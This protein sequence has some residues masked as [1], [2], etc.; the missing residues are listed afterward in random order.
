V[1]IRLHTILLA[2]TSLLT[3]TLSAQQMPGFTQYQSTVMYSNPAYAGMREGICINGLMRQQWAGF[4]DTQRGDNV[5]PQT[6][7]ITVDSPIKFLHGGLGGSIIQDN[8]AAG[9]WKDV[10]LQLSYSFH[11]DLS[12]GLLGIGAGVNLINRSI[13]GSKYDPVD[14]VDGDQALLGSEQGD[15]RADVN[16]GLFLMNPGRYYFGIAVNNILET[17]YKKLYDG[18][19]DGGVINDRTFTVN[20]AYTFLLNNPRFEIEPS[21]MIISDISSTQYNLSAIV[22]YNDR[23]WGGLNARL[24]HFESIG[25]IVGV[26]FKDFRIGY[27]YDINLMGLSV[28]GSHEVSLGYCF[29]LKGDRSKTS[30][31]NTRYL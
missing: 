11:A 6:F 25:V 9:L 26:S 12:M 23:F 1:K 29:K 14:P 19:D 24:G 28:P 7:L 21:V 31:K 13:D 4:S 22:T 27:S 10:G 30:Y 5:S 20:A 15:M 17:T 3:F 8:L 18:Q 16:F 2:V